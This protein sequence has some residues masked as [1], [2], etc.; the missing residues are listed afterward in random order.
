MVPVDKALEAEGL[1]QIQ[2]YVE[3][4]QAAIQEYIATRSVYE[5][6]AEA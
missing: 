4:W 3:Q 1:W 6:C 5:L 2:E